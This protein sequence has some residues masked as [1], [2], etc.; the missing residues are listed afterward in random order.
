MLCREEGHTLQSLAAQHPSS[1]HGFGL[2]GVVKEINVDNDGLITFQSQYF[3]NQQLYHDTQ[4]TFYH[5]LGHRKISI[6]WNP[7]TF[8]K[9]LKQVKNRTKDIP[10]NMKGEGF[11]QGGVIIFDKDGIAKYAYEE[12]TGEELP[13]EDILAALE[14]IRNNV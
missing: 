13:V 8:Y 10:G 14:A 1:L 4:H 12:I 6:P 9:V 2:F 11:I 5:A 7:W 3:H